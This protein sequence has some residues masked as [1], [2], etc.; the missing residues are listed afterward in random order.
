MTKEEKL[1]DLHKFLIKKFTVKEKVTLR[2]CKMNDYGS[3]TYDG[4]KYH[5]SVKKNDSYPSQENSI[6]HEWGHVLQKKHDQEHHSN[7]WGIQFAKV[8][9]VY[10]QWVTENSKKRKKIK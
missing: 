1:R 4:E 5:I 3:C 10:L 6:L 7:N 2:I 9:R 8:Y